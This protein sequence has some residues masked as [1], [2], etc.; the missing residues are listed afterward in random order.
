[1]I[2]NKHARQ[3]GRVDFDHLRDIGPDMSH[4]D[5]PT[6]GTMG[7]CLNDPGNP[8]IFWTLETRIG[9]LGIFREIGNPA[10]MS[11]FSFDDFWPLT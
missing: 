9:N 11:Q 3:R 4:G 6:V 5:R 2:Q 1:M 8:P 7:V 10:N